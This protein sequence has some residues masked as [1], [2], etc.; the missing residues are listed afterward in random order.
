MDE[1]ISPTT[2]IVS[3]LFEI[4][5][6][7]QPL[8]CVEAKFVERWWG[9]ARG[10]RRVQR[11]GW[12]GRG[13]DRRIE[14]DRRKERQKGRE[15]RVRE[16]WRGERPLGSRTAIETHRLT[17]VLGI[18]LFFSLSLSLLSSRFL[19]A[20]SGCAE[21]TTGFFHLGHGRF[22]RIRELEQFEKM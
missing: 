19:P 16:G 3:R 1:Q 12:P 7:G 4:S 13:I 2:P 18:F 5:T 9:S 20:T 6:R 8:F 22:R 11:V 10:V 15:Q 14:R 17:C 21:T